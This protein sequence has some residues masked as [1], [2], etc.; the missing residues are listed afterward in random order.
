M[1]IYLAI[2]MAQLSMFGSLNEIGKKKLSITI[3]FKTFTVFNAGTTDKF[4]AFSLLLLASSVF[5]VVM[6]QLV[7]CNF[8]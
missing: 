5:F 4:L 3:F 6:L 8:G 1:E 7:G 2:Y